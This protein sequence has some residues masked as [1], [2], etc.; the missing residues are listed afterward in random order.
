VKARPVKKLD[1]SRSLGENA[2]RIIRVR[3][4]EMLAFAPKA[5]S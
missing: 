4:D 3:L 1:P 5:L 2:A